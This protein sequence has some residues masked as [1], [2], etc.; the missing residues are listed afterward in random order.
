VEPEDLV[1]EAGHRVWRLAVCFGSKLPSR[2][3]GVLISTGPRS[4]L[5]RLG[6]RAVADAGA[7]RH[8]TGR[9]SRVLDHLRIQRRLDD[10]PGE[11]RQQPARAREFLRLQAA[12]GVVER[13]LVQQV[14]EAVHDLLRWLI[15]LGAIRAPPAGRVTV[16]S[17]TFALVVG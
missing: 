9:V 4:R 6:R 5:Q 15:A 2:S 7:E 13:P 11:L 1:G 12:N 10:P 14:R 8:A 17:S 3:R 16:G